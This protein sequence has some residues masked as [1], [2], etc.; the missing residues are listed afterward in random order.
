MLSWGDPPNSKYIHVIEN[1][2]TVTC[3]LMPLTKNNK[4]C[5]KTSQ[6]SVEVF[7]TDT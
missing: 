6:K 5:N 7:D 3:D 4:Q 2:D 1:W